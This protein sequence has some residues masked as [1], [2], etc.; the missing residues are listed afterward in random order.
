M[1]RLLLKLLLLK[2]ERKR[3]AITPQE[4]NS[5]WVIKFGEF[6][7]YLEKHIIETRNANDYADMMRI[8]YKHLNEICK[9][10]SGKTAK[11]FIDN[12]V[13]L[14]IKRQLATS[15]HSIKELAYQLG[16]DEPTNF[17]KYFK[18]RT[19]RSPAQFKKMLIK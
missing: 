7:N 4:G 5:A 6:R 1:L 15:D 12:Y 17:V 8:S 14:E 13:V 18:K 19:N 9:S 11:E 3:H 2:A 16:F 10:I